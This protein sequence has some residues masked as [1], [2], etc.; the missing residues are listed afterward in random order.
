MQVVRNVLFWLSSCREL[1]CAAGMTS[2]ATHTLIFTC[3]FL[4]Q[5]D[6]GRHVAVQGKALEFY[7]GYIHIK[8]FVKTCM[9][10]TR[11]S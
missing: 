5:I 2:S 3:S 10:I 7:L 8:N 11:E 9:Q 4:L 6:F 1:T